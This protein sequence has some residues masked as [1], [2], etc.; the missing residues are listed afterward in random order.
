[1]LILQSEVAQSIARE[2]NVFLTA[3]EK[4]S[5][6]SNRVV[7]PDA[8]Q[9]VIKGDFL[10]DSQQFER[11]TE[12]YER[13]IEIDP[14]HAE[15]YSG[16]SF[17]FS[18]RATWAREPAADVLPQ[19]K[20]AVVKA[21]EIDGSLPSAHTA[22]AEIAI[23]ERDWTKAE[24]AFKRAIQL[25]P[26]NSWAHHN[27][28]AI[29]WSLGR[30]DEAIAEATRA[31]QLN[32]LA[33]LINAKIVG[34]HGAASRYEDAIQEGRSA[35]ALNPDF[36][37]VRQ[38]LVWAYINAGRYQKA[39]T[40]A[41]EYVKRTDGSADS[42]GLLARA[43]A[44]AGQVDEAI[45]MQRSNVESNPD[46]APGYDRLGMLYTESG[47]LGEATHSL[48]RA[49]AIV[50]N[51]WMYMRLVRRY[52][53]LGDPDRVT[54]LMALRG[55][56]N[57][58]KTHTLAIRHLLQCY[59]GETEE[60]LETARLLADQAERPSILPRRADHLV[61]LR[62]LQRVEP[63]T[64]MVAYARLYPELLRDPPS[65]TTGNYGAAASLALLHLQAGDEDRSVNLLRASLTTIESQPASERGFA[66]VMV[67][68]IQGNLREATAALDRDLAAGWRMDWWLL[69]VEPVFEPLWGLPEFQAR[70]AEVETEMAA[71]LAN[72]REMERNGE[73]A[74]I[75]RDETTLH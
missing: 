47:R 23:A 72:L 36:R 17:S 32:P 49:F 14:G 38:A 31:Q 46:Y 1:V 29:L 34:L 35:L 13:A 41:R 28:S 15:A 39:I 52:L 5:L 10:L 11:A 37:L 8:Y 58:D 42:V 60:A 65:V 4:T 18:L 71:Q 66:D 27:Y 16:L 7:D 2:I 69:R 19:A 54:Q 73:L 40:E 67:H 62:D 74:A 75:P 24:E 12:A 45:E 20:A 70:M 43:M 6:A 25:D 63:E 57:P 26:S 9:W 68:T 3:D 53:A 56:L 30:I 44:A 61:W 59:R 55:N 33:D 64:A 48:A 22:M 21:L 51:S 50:P